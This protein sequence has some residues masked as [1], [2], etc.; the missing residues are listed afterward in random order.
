[1]KLYGVGR[2][3]ASRN[4]WMLAEMDA[5]YEQVPVI[6]A[7]RLADPHAADAPLNTRSPDFLAVNPAGTIPALVDGETVI[8]ESLAI[9]LYLAGIAG[10]P[11]GPRNAAET[12][13][14]TQ[15]A[16]YTATMIEADAI[17]VF[18]VH[19]KGRAG[20]EAGKAD[21]AAVMARLAWPLRWVEARI[22]DEGHPVGGRF[23]VADINLA[24]VLRFVQDDP[25]YLEPYP[26]IRRWL[27]DC[28]ARPAFQKMW[29]ARAAEPV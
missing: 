24:E 22:A 11:L 14:M 25:S 13:Q 17:N 18:Y 15:W 29:T 4:M 23:T 21:A 16:L 20:T 1:M 28:Q 2:S 3:R 6:Q 5:P 12:A 8:W 9:N 7:Y 10:A 27:A 26:A 19:A